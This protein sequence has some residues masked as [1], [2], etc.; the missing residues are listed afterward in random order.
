MNWSAR[1]L[2]RYVRSERGRLGGE[3]ALRDQQGLRGRCD[4]EAP[5]RRPQNIYHQRRLF[6]IGVAVIVVLV[7]IAV[8]NP[9]STVPRKYP[10]PS[11]APA[12][13][14]SS[15]AFVSGYPRTAREGRGGTPIAGRGSEGFPPD[16]NGHPSG[17]TFLPS[18]VPGAR[19]TWRPVRT[20]A[21]SRARC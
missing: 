7:C 19:R 21:S 18:V 5:R 4:T 11:S 1:R 3:R 17:S 13:R 12:A 16:P 9:G 6:V 2:A 20:P 10:R 15:A 14:R 8:V